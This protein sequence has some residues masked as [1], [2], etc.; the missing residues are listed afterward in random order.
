MSLIS[1]KIV[2][3]NNMVYIVGVHETTNLVAAHER[4]H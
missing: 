1:M 3:M 2:K 4:F